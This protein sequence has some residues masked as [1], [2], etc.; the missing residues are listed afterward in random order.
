MRGASG[1]GTPRTDTHDHT[2]P[3]FLEKDYFY[4]YKYRV[5]ISPLTHRGGISLRDSVFPTCHLGVK[6][7]IYTHIYAQHTC[8]HI[9]IH[10]ITMLLSLL[11]FRSVP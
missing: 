10:T 6:E 1:G 11:S 8:T 5:L 9:Y 2:H 3:S 4:R 7:H